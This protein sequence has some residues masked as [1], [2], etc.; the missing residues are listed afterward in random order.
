MCIKR[1]NI[2]RSLIKFN[3]QKEKYLT[4]G[5]ITKNTHQAGEQLNIV[6]ESTSPRS[7]TSPVMAVSERTQRSVNSETRTVAMATPAEGPSL[8]IAPAGK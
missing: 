7:V 4:S 6:T 3:T 8:L 5:R 2:V 1:V